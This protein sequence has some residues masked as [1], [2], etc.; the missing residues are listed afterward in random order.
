MPLLTLG[1]VGSGILRST[2]TIK[3]PEIIFGIA[4]VINLVFDYLLG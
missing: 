3:F 2:G 1:F 4:G